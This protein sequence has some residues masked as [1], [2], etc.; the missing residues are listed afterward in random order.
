MLAALLTGLLLGA[1]SRYSSSLAGPIRWLGNLGAIWLLVA[2]GLGRSHASSRQAAAAGALALSAAPIAHYVP[3]R[4]ARFGFSLEVVRWYMVLW[5]VFGLIVGAL[6][7]YLGSRRDAVGIAL[8]SAALA[9]ESVLLWFLGPTEA[10]LIA[11]PI[12]LAFALL[13]PLSL[14]ARRLR[15]YG[16]ALVVLPVAMAVLWVMIVRIG[17]VYP[18]L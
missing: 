17:R 3:Y 11:V 6:F 13:L 12:Q 16:L 15:A 4:V 18:T 9:G 1:L 14:P 7:G 8:T 5:L 2:Y 10:R